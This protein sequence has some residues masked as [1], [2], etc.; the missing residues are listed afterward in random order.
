MGDSRS[1]Q[2]PPRPP[3]LKNVHVVNGHSESRDQI[4]YFALIREKPRP[5]GSAASKQNVPTQKQNPSASKSAA[6]Q[7]E[8]PPLHIEPGIETKIFANPAVIFL[9]QQ[10]KKLAIAAAISFV[11]Y[12][13]WS[14]V[15]TLSS[16]STREPA[17]ITNPTP[18]VAANNATEKKP[19]AAPP[20]ASKLGLGNPKRIEPAPRADFSAPN[21]STS[22]QH[23]SEDNRAGESAQ[24]YSSSEAAPPPPETPAEALGDAMNNY[25]NPNPYPQEGYDAAGN[26]VTPPT[27]IQN[28]PPDGGPNF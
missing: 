10:K 12:A 13:S 18:A 26:A 5:P 22:V 16:Q 1:W 19:D 8:H 25:N 28:P 6:P 17:A 11:S 9:T 4:D 3:E 24:F 27:L 7:T 21:I 15:H 2:P 20:A 23:S 14:I